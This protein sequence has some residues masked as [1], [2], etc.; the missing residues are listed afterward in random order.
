MKPS[1]EGLKIS[2]KEMV[3]IKFEDNQAKGNP[4]Q[5]KTEYDLRLRNERAWAAPTSWDMDL[6]GQL[7]AS[8]CGPFL[9]GNG[10]TKTVWGPCLGSEHVSVTWLAFKAE[11]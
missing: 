3:A 8:Q 4:N 10:S 11:S 9:N 1:C 5:L 7:G 6:L 2:T